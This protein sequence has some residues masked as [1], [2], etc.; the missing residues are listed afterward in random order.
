[1]IVETAENGR[2]INVYELPRHN[3]DVKLEEF[4]NNWDIFAH[5]STWCSAV[6]AHKW[7]FRPEQ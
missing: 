5:V 3:F 6:T 2:Y 4:C 7:M 1:M